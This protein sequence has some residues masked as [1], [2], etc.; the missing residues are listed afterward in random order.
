MIWR[1]ASGGICIL[2][3]GLLV[4]AYGN[5]RERAGKAKTEAL[6]QATVAAAQVQTMQRLALKIAAADTA[7][8][9]RHR[10]AERDSNASRDRWAEVIEIA[11]VVLSLE[12]GLPADGLRALQADTA[13]ANA[14]TARAWGLDPSTFGDAPAEP[15]AGA[16]L[17]WADLGPVFRDHVDR[18]RECQ[19]D[20]RA[21]IEAW[22]E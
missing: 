10:E 1:L 16:V 8:I 19:I 12:Y 20:R 17:T 13:A 2:L 11:P 9:E 3:A 14:A 21:L 22:P 6:W 4:W 18:W 15:G 5:A 7:A